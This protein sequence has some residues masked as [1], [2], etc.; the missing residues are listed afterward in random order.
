MAYGV[1]LFSKPTYLPGEKQQT[2]HVIAIF[3][4]PKE[5]RGE[6][7]QMD[8]LQLQ[9]THLQWQLEDLGKLVGA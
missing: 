7:G 8:F 9:R 1:R 6:E 3:K 4:D 2:G 5:D